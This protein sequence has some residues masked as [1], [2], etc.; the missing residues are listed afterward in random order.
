MRSSPAGPP[1]Q[2]SRTSAVGMPRRV[3]TSTGRASLREELPKTTLD[4]AFKP[5]SKLR[6]ANGRNL[7]RRFAKG[8]QGWVQ[9]KRPASQVVP[10]DQAVKRIAA[11]FLE[12]EPSRKLLVLLIDGM[13]WAQA[14]EIL[15]SLGSRAWGPIA[16]HASKDG[17]IRR[18]CLPGHVGKLSN[19]HGGESLGFLCGKADDAGS[20]SQHERRPEMV[21]GT[22]RCLQAVRAVRSIPAFSS[23]QRAT[24]TTALRRGKLSALSATPRREWLRS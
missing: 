13:A 2:T 24:P 8:L 11:R 12:Q 4:A 21:D 18:R 14:V 5:W 7:D 10:I 9:A 19:R 15:D 6:T 17:R 23:A 3:V 16:W 20:A 1:M 22:P